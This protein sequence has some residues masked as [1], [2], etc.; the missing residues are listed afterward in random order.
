MKS[1]FMIFIMLFLV[2]TK[3]VNA[4][5]WGC[6]DQEMKCLDKNGIEKGTVIVNQDWKSG[7]CEPRRGKADVELGCIAEYGEGSRVNGWRSCTD[8]FGNNACN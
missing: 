1:F 5:G 7:R 3:T 2:E 4:A 6:P 8:I